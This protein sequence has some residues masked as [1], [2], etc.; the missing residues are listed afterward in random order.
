MAQ[1]INYWKLAIWKASIGSLLCAAGVLPS[2]IL[3]WD[4]MTNA[5][6]LVAILGVIVALGKFLDGF[7]DQTFSR[8]AQ[9]RPLVQLPGMNGHDEPLTEG[10]QISTQESKVQVKTTTTVEPPTVTTHQP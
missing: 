5:G 4:T 8:M 6:R 2:L 3:N 10:T 9:G 7:F 1:I